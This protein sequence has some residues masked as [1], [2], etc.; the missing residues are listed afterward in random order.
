MRK[1]RGRTEAN[2]IQIHIMLMHK[3]AGFQFRVTNH[4]WSALV[5]RGR[6]RV[7]A[8][9]LSAKYNVLLRL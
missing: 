9:S 2:K 4:T 5:K 3:K 6:T 1:R 7:L 8:S